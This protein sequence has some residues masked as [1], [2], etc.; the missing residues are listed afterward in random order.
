MKIGSRLRVVPHLP[1]ATQLGFEHSPFN[2]KIQD[3]AP[4]PPRDDKYQLKWRI[5]TQ[6]N[7]CH[8]R[9]NHR[10]EGHRTF[11][12]LNWDVAPGSLQTSLREGRGTNRWGSFIQK[13]GARMFLKGGAM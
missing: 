2:S 1:N 13:E 4:V 8:R 10:R 3:P 11:L 12:Q 7:K 6:V 9:K 5:S